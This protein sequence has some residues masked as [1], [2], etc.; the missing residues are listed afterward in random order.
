MQ[1]TITF[2]AG[3]DVEMSV[4]DELPG[5]PAVVHFQINAIG[6]RARLDQLGHRLG[7]RAPFSQHF[8]RQIKQIDEVG[9]GN[10]ESMTQINRIDVQ[11]SQKMLIFPDFIARNLAGHDFAKETVNHKGIIANA[12]W[13][14][15]PLCYNPFNV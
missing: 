7:G 11:K 8:G 15:K 6:L 12:D 3:D 1:K 13:Q 9:F 5:R 2:K 14:T 4:V 10:Q